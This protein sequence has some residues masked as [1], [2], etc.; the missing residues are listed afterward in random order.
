MLLIFHIC[1]IG[2]PPKPK[3]VFSY[4]NRDNKI[5]LR[6]KLRREA[7]ERLAEEAEREAK[8]K[9]NR[10]LA[11]RMKKER[12]VISFFPSNRA[13]HQREWE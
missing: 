3:K 6:D 5:P 8:L 1:L 9:A 12:F 2:S 10:A 4:R 13:I 7:E 11:L